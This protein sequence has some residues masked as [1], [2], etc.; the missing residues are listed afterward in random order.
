MVCIVAK[1]VICIT[2][3][4]YCKEGCSMSKISKI[5][6]VVAWFY[7]KWTKWSGHVGSHL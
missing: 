1:N 5:Q 6:M 7:N 2:M 3:G 4:F